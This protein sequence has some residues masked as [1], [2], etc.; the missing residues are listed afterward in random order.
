M[1]AAESGKRRTWLRT[2][3]V[4]APAASPSI[5]VVMPTFNRCEVLEPAV[6]RVLGQLADGD[7]LV[8]VD[9]GSTDRTLEVL[10]SI[11]D[12]RLRVVAREN[13]GISAARNSGV[14]AAMG[15]FVLPIDDDDVPLPHWLSGLRSAIAGEP[16]AVASC[17]YQIVDAD[18]GEIA[19]S[20]LPSRLGPVFSGFVGCF[21]AGTFVVER[22]F[23]L[24]VGGFTEG[25]QCS[26]QTEFAMRA[27][28]ACRVQDRRV[29]HVDDALLQ[30][31]RRRA[32]E[33]PESSPAKLYSGTSWILE[34]R[35]GLLARDPAVWALYM[36]VAG[37]N[38]F[39]LDERR[40][41]RRYL[42]SAARTDPRRFRH[43]TRLAVSFVPI[44]ARRVW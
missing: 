12:D 39:K 9:D 41:A 35:A 37:V 29:A 6:R 33:R 5:S 7:E 43:W 28:D 42:L 19:S 11:E 22:D 31:M 13:G 24:S 36:G 16:T 38:A 27:L 34:H 4:V 1:G 2:V 18:T 30:V 32:D 17:G 40:A 10:E 15:Q 8:V 23:Y 44:V 20:H 26:H 3:S 25:L 21:L 14:A